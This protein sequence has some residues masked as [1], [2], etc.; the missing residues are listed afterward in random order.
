M[1]V[2]TST[3]AGVITL[4]QFMPNAIAIGDDYTISAGCDKQLATCKTKF[5]NVVN[6]RGFPHVPG[7]DMMVSGQ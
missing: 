2:K 7:Q 6:F 1:E 4:Q 3:S 5:N